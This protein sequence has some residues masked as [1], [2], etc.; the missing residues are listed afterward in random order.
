MENFLNLPFVKAFL[1]ML[2][3]FSDFKGRTSR[4]EYWWAFLGNFILSLIVGVI[5]G[6]LGTFGTI[7]S[8]IFSIALLVPGLAISVR[9]LHDTNR[10]GLWLLLCLTG[11]GSIVILV[12]E[13]LEGDEGDNQY[14]PN[15]KYSEQ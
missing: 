8:W 11:I 2:A 5:C 6:L 15:P 14:G 3:N 4:N 7:L 10:S 9:R 13:I 12:F 1:R